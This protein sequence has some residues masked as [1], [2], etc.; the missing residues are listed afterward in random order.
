VHL[1][2]Q[3]RAGQGD[4]GARAGRRGAGRLRAAR[5]HE[6]S[7]VTEDNL[8]LDVRGSPAKQRSAWRSLEDC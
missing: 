6:S 1:C 4:A 5:L 7:A 2:Q 3:V 8:T